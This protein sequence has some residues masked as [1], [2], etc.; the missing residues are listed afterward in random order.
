VSGA[1][2]TELADDAV[3]DT[4]AAAGIVYAP[5]YVVNAGG[6]INIAQEWAP[7]GYSTERA[8][9]ETARI[10]E[11][12]TRVLEVAADEKISPA[13]AADELAARRIATEGGDRW[14]APGDPS[15]MRDA[16]LERR[17]RFR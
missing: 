7:G 13:R 9:A 16:L 4:L 8:C 2:N 12:T 15:E 1:A 10:E 14:Y 3:A 6:I 11:T 5:D 17:Q